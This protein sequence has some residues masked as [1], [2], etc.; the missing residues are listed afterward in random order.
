MSGDDGKRFAPIFDCLL[1]SSGGPPKT[2]ESATI[3]CEEVIPGEGWV[4]DDCLSR[5]ECQK[6]IAKCEKSGF[7]DA[8]SFC[9]M[10]VNR[11]ND[12]M[13][14]DDARLAEYLWKRVRSYAPPEMSVAN[15]TWKVKGLNTRFRVCRY[16]KG[17]YF[18]PHRD[19]EVHLS[20]TERS[21]FTCMLYLNDG[22]VDFEGGATKFLN[23]RSP[24]TTKFDVLPKAG[25]C[26]VFRQSSP[27]TLHEGVKLASGTKFILRTDVMYTI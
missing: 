25:R 26:I 3:P 23:D 18:G 8:E 16:Y 1:D 19:G 4:L 17:H 7:E 24:L 10:Y 20:V 9:F 14:T 11:L 2:D 27:N 13:M 22:D 15:K 21:L 12:R 5:E 6:I